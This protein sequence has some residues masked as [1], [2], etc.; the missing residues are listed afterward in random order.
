MENNQ[1]GQFLSRPRRLTRRAALLGEQRPGVVGFGAGQLN[2]APGVQSKMSE[3][4]E[5]TDV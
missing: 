2:Q 3:M 5:S 1:P 4:Q